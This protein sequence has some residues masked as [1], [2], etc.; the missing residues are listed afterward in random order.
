M[1]VQEIWRVV[2]RFEDRQIFLPQMQVFRL[3]TVEGEEKRVVGV[4]GVEQIHGTEIE[5]G[6]SWYGRQ[7]RVKQGV[8]FFIKLRVV[9]AEDFVELSASGVHFGRIEVINDDA[10]RE[11]PEIVAFNFEFFDARA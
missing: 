11:L 1:E 7:K 2:V 8:F 5:S 6:A 3:A 4:V 10:Q 9:N